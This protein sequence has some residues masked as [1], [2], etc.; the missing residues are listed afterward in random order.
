M[1]A[2]RSKLEIYLNVLQIIK[3]GTEKPTRIM[4][5]ANL[6]WKPLQKILDAMT[7]QGLINGVEAEDGDD[8]RTTKIYE[9]SQKGENVLRYFVRAKEL[10]PLE[11]II[12]I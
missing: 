8:K 9:I 12:K 3:S 6:S 1:T 10:L 4:Y 5:A 7:T 11:D 2:R